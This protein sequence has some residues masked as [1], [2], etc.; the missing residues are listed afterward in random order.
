MLAPDYCCLSAPDDHHHQNA[1]EQAYHADASASNPN[2]TICYDCGSNQRYRRSIRRRSPRLSLF[3]GVASLLLRLCILFPGTTCAFQNRRPL[4]TVPRHE[5]HSKGIKLARATLPHKQPKHQKQQLQQSWQ[6]WEGDDLRKSSKLRRRL[7]RELDFGKQPVRNSLIAVT[8]GV[9]LYQVFDTV[10][11]V[12][13]TYPHVWPRQALSIVWDTVIGNARPGPLTWNFLHATHLSRRQP[14]RY[15]TAGFLH[16]SLIHL[17]LNLNALRSLPSWLETGLGAPLY[18][19]TFVVSVV[20]GN[21]ADTVLSEGTATRL[22]LGA[23]G[24]ICG[25]FGMLYV[26]LVRMGNHAAAWRVIKGMAWLVAYGLVS[27]NI[28]NAG[29]M[30]GFVAGAIL[31][32]LTGPSYSKSYALRRKNSLEVDT[33]ISKEYR[34]AIGYDKRPSARGWLPLPV[35]WLAALVYLS[36]EARFRAMPQLVWRGLTMRGSLL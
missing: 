16:G 22:C 6:N 31:T 5:P 23:S 17:L 15:L 13:R 20:G 14:H 28:S 9:Y 7:R 33:N 12:R 2:K 26:S 27:S 32:L 8:V 24:G 29:H 3:A 21:L 36:S 1:E 19:T 18:W 25:L 35:V 30:G 10:A 34:T 4:Q 11:W